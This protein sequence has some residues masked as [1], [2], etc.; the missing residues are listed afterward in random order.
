MENPAWFPVIDALGIPMHGARDRIRAL[1]NKKL[2]D[3]GIPQQTLQLLPY[4]PTIITKLGP[5]GVLVTEL[6]GAE[7]PKLK[8]EAYA[9]YIL[10]RRRNGTKVVGGVYMRYYPAQPIL[11]A[12]IKSVNGAGDTFVGVVVAGLASGAEL[13]EKLITLAQVAALMTMKSKLSV[14]KSIKH[15]K[16]NLERL[17]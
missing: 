16:M 12:D 6:L 13:D 7:S 5:H 9:P 2:V 8:S 10:S 4:I 3:L 11:P 1:T 17:L 14:S 15:L